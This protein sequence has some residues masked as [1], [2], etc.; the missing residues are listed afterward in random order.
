MKNKESLFIALITLL[1]LLVTS[2][3]LIF[4]Y[5]S[6]PNGK[7]FMGIVYGT[8]DSTQYLTWM[9]SFQDDFFINNRM[10]AEDTEFV[11]F[12]LLWWFLGKVSSATNWGLSVVFQFF[13][14]LTVVIY[15]PLVFW[16]IGLFL[17]DTLQRWMAFLIV[18]LGAGLGWL[19]VIE[20]Y[21]I[22]GELRW[23]FDL[24]T[25]EPNSFLS[26][27]AF[28]HFSNAAIFIFSIFSLALLAFERARVTY[29]LLAGFLSL[30]LGF[31]HAYD[32][33]LIYSVIGIYAIA[34]LFKGYP[35]RRAIGY[36]A[37]VG[38]LSCPGAFFNFYITEKF[39]T[40][41]DVL[42]Q[43]VNA[44]AWSPAPLHL[45][46]LLG[47]PFIL[48]IIGFLLL[49]PFI[50][51]YSRDLFIKIWF[52]VQLLL[53]YLPVNYQIHYLNGL[54][55][56][57]AILATMTVFQLIIQLLKRKKIG[58]TSQKLPFEP[59]IVG[60]F[61]LLTIPTNLYLLS[62]RVFDLGRHDYP[63]YLRQ[64]DVEALNW[65]D[66]HGKKGE[67]V[68]SSFDVGQYIPNHTPMRAF[69]AHWAMTLKLYEKEDSV[70]RFYSANWTNIDRQTLLEEFKIRYVLWGEA[71][72][73]IGDF[74]PTEA[75]YLENV[76]ST[77]QTSL[78]RVIMEEE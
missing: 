17:K 16:T 8:P 78:F 14:L 7:A 21:S 1:L 5:F 6:A 12:N 70:N 77:P 26:L 69:L 24:Y 10:T 47:I 38:F 52:L 19:L 67:V 75:T 31:I 65:L 58:S 13:R 64:G 48:A 20:K 25:V 74:D 76:F 37:I 18:I 11:F 28:P 61:V 4:G 59:I 23:P 3:P 45:P 36:T 42:D 44:G 34:L 56:P 29:I 27:M 22:T 46:I 40:W 68:L 51:D 55:L 41:R 66:E 49:R 9:R 33:I 30:L 60:L 73:R 2:L 62:W 63:Y 15:V 54:Q 32:L 39:D 71:E 57:I 50:P 35:W 43:F 53:I 72:Q